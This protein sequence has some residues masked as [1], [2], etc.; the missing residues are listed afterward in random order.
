MSFEI[1]K[2]NYLEMVPLIGIYLTTTMSLTSTS[3][4]LTVLVLHL[5]HAGQFAP[6]LPRK[7][8]YFMTKKVAFYVGMNSTVRR[9]ESMDQKDKNDRNKNDHIKSA[10]LNCNDEV[11]SLKN[12]LCI[13]K[14]DSIKKNCRCNSLSTCIFYDHSELNKKSSENLQ[15]SI[16]NTLKKSITSD[17]ENIN[18]FSTMNKQPSNLNEISESSTSLS[19]RKKHQSFMIPISSMCIECSRVKQINKEHIDSLNIFSKYL[20]EFIKKDDLSCHNNNLQNEWKLVALIVDRVLFWL[21]S[22]LT[23]VSSV[24]LL[25][26]LPILKNRELIKPYSNSKE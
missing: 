19:S 11:L 8:Y 21:F 26:V 6:T 4:V 16:Q 2:K 15:K 1:N 7:F 3:I 25:L 22:I 14:D 23:I 13:I 12:S 24:I 17:N 9:Y 20:K 18:N 10:I 5:H